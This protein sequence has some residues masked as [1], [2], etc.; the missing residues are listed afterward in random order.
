MDC[1]AADGGG[2]SM[3]EVTRPRV[4]ITGYGLAGRY[5]HAPLLK[6]AGFD[7]V[8]AVTSHPGRIS[9]L[10]EDFPNA[11]AVKTVEELI[12][13]KI[14]LLVVATANIVHAKEAIAGLRA[15]VPVVVD[16]PMALNLEQTEN[17]IRVAEETG[18]PVT[19]YFS[20]RWDS[21]ALTV[22]RVIRE[23]LLGDI[24]RMDSR[25][26]RFRPEANPHSWRETTPEA[27]GGGLVLDLQPHLVS[28]ALD[29]FGPAEL[30]FSSVRAIRGGA[31]DDSVLVLKHENGIDSYLSASAVQGSPGP[32][33]RISGTKGSLVVF[34][35][36]PQEDLLRSGKYPKDGSWDV[37][38]ATPAFFFTG[39]EFT[40]IVG[41]NGNYCEFYLAVKSAL[42][43]KSAWPVPV[44]DSLAVARILD[45]ARRISIR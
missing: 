44:E 22:K 26:E 25:F 32:R 29:W 41:E 6:G 37:P 19:T 33:L 21:D 43:G 12:A 42:G 20:R 1:R 34:D 28:L 5:F 39:S 17:I 3:S 2:L 4:G 10:K 36:D 38:T 31:D 27:E 11:V 9:H 13:L 35:L 23:G 8:G 16:K 45:E 18:V 40:E 24:I 15:G 30:K 14:D 7:V